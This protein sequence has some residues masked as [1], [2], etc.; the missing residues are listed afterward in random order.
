MKNL[1][2]Y[3][4]REN[5]F[6]AIIKAKLLSL[7]THADRQNVADCLD[8]A[9]SPENLM[10]DGEISAAEGRRKYKFLTACADELM[11]LDPSVRMYEYGAY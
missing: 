5:Q 7:D 9:L 10:C 1:N 3:I 6:K 4:A 2:A 8:C 11:K